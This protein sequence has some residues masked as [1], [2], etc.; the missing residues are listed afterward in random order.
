M[1][2]EYIKV[3]IFIIGLIALESISY[4]L[5]KLSPIEATLLTS[6]F[7]S[8]LPLVPFFVF[9]Y[10]SWYILLFVVPLIFYLKDREKIFKYAATSVICIVISFLVFFFFPTTIVRPDIE[11][12]NVSTFL[13]NFIYF[14][15]TPA[16]NCLPSMHCALCYLFIY[17]S[18]KVKNVKWYYKVL[19]I[20]DS[21]LVVASTMFIKQH[22]IWDALAALALVAISIILNKKLK[23]HEK[24]AQKF[25]KWLAK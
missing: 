12:T 10:Y 6:S 25:N 18:F 8:A 11:V 21:L 5:A 19:I 4:F 23:L 9:F 3:I 2:K 7:D 20:I 16:L 14:T 15:D 24:I 22:V 13:L 1:K 17:F